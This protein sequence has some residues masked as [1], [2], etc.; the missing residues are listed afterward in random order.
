MKVCTWCKRF[1]DANVD[2]EMGEESTYKERE[3]GNL[4]VEVGRS[5]YVYGN[6]GTD[7]GL[8]EISLQK[9]WEWIRIGHVHRCIRIEAQIKG[10]N[11][12]TK[13]NLIGHSMGGKVSMFFAVNYPELVGK[14]I[15]VDIG[16]RY[17]KPH[18]S[19]ILEA[20]NTVNFSIQT[21]R[22]KVEDL[23]PHAW[24]AFKT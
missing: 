6:G 22:K 20:L 18:H 13:V 1:F 5:K 17:Y 10:F 8:D 12:A 9:E 16:P 3:D 23:L 7:A 19:E 2:G 4:Y 11:L 14:L 24:I 21:S 15:V